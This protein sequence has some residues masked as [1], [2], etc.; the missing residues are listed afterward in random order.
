MIYLIYRYYYDKNIMTKVHG[1]RYAYRFDFNGLMA[2]CQAQA[3]GT[4][5]T[6]S[7]ISATYTKYHHAQ[8]HSSLVQSDPYP[9]VYNATLP[10]AST[11]S[12]GSAV[13]VTSSGLV[14][15]T[16]TTT[17][18][19]TT[20]SA[21]FPAPPYWPYSPPTAFDPRSGHPFN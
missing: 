6:N 11:S 5:P 1:K 7:M 3:Q 16:S 13:A 8:P 9:S 21:I 18:T 4:D 12:S 10:T 19:T 15:P 2:A 17:S 20:T 14:K